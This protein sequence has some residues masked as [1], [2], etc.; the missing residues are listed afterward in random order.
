VHLH[1]KT[2]PSECRFAWV[3]MHTSSAARGGGNGNAPSSVISRSGSELGVAV[4]PLV[5]RAKSNVI[6]RLSASSHPLMRMVVVVN[7]S[8]SAEAAAHFRGTRPAQCSS[9][10]TAGAKHVHVPEGGTA[11]RRFH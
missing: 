6:N 8:Q 3:V 10:Y 7:L 1:S 2:K 5:A 11:G 4:F 9:T